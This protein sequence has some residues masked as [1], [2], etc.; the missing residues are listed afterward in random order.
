MNK[1]SKISQIKGN[2]TTEV[3]MVRHTYRNGLSAAV[4]PLLCER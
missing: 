1:F 4:V 3:T 2:D